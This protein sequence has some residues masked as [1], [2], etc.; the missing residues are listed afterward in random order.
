MEYPARWQGRRLP[1]IR[2][3]V[4]EGQIVWGLTYRFLESFLRIVGQ[5]LPDRWSG[6]QL[7]Q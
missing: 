5:P 2:V 1:G 6:P 3:G 7:G 4:P